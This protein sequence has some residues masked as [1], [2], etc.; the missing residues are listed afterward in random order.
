MTPFAGF[1]DG[2]LAAT[3]IPNLFFARLLPVVRHLV[4]LPAG[5]ARMP[6]AR[7]S[8][9]TL[10]GSFLWCTVLSWFGLYGPRGMS[11]ELVRR[12]NEEVVKA[13]QTPE[14]VARY[15]QLGVDPAKLSPAEFGAYV[16]ADS[17]RWGRIVK[18]RNIKAE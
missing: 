9:S 15:A 18:E 13:L 7:F 14:M 10:L 6:F 17:A 11:P 3:P 12:I 5:A 2:A 16:T 4:S 1:P 8:L